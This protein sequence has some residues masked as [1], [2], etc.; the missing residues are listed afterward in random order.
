GD[1]AG[2]RGSAGEAGELRRLQREGEPVPGES[3]GS[4]RGR[5]CPVL[6]DE[7]GS[8]PA[9]RL[10]RGGRDLR[11]RVPGWQPEERARGRA[12]V[13]GAGGWWRGLRDGV[14]GG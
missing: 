13:H 8:E 4:E 10:P 1:A 3:A 7:R 2:L 5:P 9:Q 14:R 6:R 12:D 11:P